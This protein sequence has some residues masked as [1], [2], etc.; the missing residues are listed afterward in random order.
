M[1]DGRGMYRILIRKPQGKIQLGGL[2][3]MW[4]DNIKMELG[5]IGIDGANCIG[6]HDS[7]AQ[8][9]TI[10]ITVINFLFE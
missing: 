1:V 4:V 6:L 2:R 10:V 9:R 3:R 8:W 5:E 7:G